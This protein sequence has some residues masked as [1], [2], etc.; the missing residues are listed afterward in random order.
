MRMRESLGTC[1]LLDSV[2]RDWKLAN[3]LPDQAERAQ[4]W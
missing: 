1:V 3:L 4:K 2:S